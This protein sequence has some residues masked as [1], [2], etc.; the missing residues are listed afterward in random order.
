MKRVVR[1][2]NGKTEVLTVEQLQN[3]SAAPKKSKRVTAPADTTVATTTATAAVTEEV[4]T[5]AAPAKKK[6]GSSYSSRRKQQAAA[7]KQEQEQ[8]PAT[9]QDPEDMVDVVTVTEAEPA[10]LLGVGL[11]EVIHLSTLPPDHVISL[12][13]NSITRTPLSLTATEGEQKQ[14]QDQDKIR[15]LQHELASMKNQIAKL[16]FGQ[17]EEAAPAD[18]EPNVLSSFPASAVST[19]TKAPSAPPPPPPPPPAGFVAPRPAAA[20]KLENPTV[21]ALKNGA[22]TLQ[23]SSSSSSLSLGDIENG[24]VKLKKTNRL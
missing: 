5:E 18:S 17:A 1:R 13:P 19:P 10:P 15:R 23:R 21:T 24:A 16:L 2:V 3:V 4:P 6:S 20:A 22:P 11:A 12:A 7:K 9:T 8:E 14:P